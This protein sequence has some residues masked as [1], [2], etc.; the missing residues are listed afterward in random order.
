M[1]LYSRRRALELAAATPFALSA[2]RP[3]SGQATTLKVGTS[4]SV[5]YAQPLYFTATGAPAKSGIAMDI[6]LFF[7]NVATATACAN[8]TIDIGVADPIAI[9]N[10][11]EHG[12]PFRIIANG[13]VYSAG[14]VSPSICVARSSNITS[15]KDLNGMAVGTITVVSSMAFVATKLWLASN[16]AD[17]SS[18]RFVEMPFPAMGPA[19]ERGTVAAAAITEPSLLNLPAGVRVLANPNPVVG[20]RYA[21][22]VWFAMQPWLDRNAALAR[23]LPGLIYDLGRW[24]NDHPA[25]TSAL[26]DAATKMDLAVVRAMRR[27]NFATGNN[28]QAITLSLAAA[29]KVNALS[30]PVSVAE[31]TATSLRAFERRTSW[32]EFGTLRSQAKIP[33][34]Q[35]H[36]SRRRSDCA[37]CAA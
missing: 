27:A 36:F 34:S 14:D 9:A 17:V 4:P 23:R 24:A 32:H 12:I 20:G 5:A 11:V 26:L 6:S 21:Q 13:S 1:M 35:R 8:G 30:R 31:L 29:L 3:A 22:T 7:S 33:R 16:G 28:P 25:D 19:I 15:A 10:G 2:V 18:I 37:K